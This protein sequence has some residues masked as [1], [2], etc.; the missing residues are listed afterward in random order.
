MV[1]YITIVTIIFQKD[2]DDE[3]DLS[4]LRK[5]IQRKNDLLHKLRNGS[6][7]LY[8]REGNRAKRADRI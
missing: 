2:K 1:Y 4:Q 3:N 6:C 8:G 7:P 5:G